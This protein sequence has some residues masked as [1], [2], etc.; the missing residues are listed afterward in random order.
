MNFLILE[1]SQEIKIDYLRYLEESGH[2]IYEFWSDVDS[3]LVDAIIIRSKIVVDSDLLRKFPNLKYVCRVG[4]WLEKVDLKLCED[5]WIKVLNTPGANSWSVADLVVWRILSLLRKTKKSWNSLDDRFL[6]MWE[7]LENKKIWFIGFG[8]IAKKVYARLGWFEWNE[9]CFY[10]PYISTDEWVVK[11]IVDKKEI[12]ENCDIISFH[13]PLTEETKNFLWKDDFKLLKQNVK[14]INTSRWWI[15]DEEALYS[16]LR[17]NSEAWAMLDTWEEE[18][19]N[20]KEKL[21]NL[22]NCIITTHIGAM[23]QESEKEMHYFREFGG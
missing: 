16:F 18:P 13:I 1:N 19:Q 3:D 5:R 15:V 11:K 7:N 17:E 20:P 12:F 6:F 22:E 9:F 21:K 14:I 10:D 4:V 8:N 23:T 2:K